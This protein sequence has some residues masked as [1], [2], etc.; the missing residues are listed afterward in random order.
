MNASRSASFHTRPHIALWLSCALLAATPAFAAK[1]LGW[2][3]DALALE[4]SGVSQLPAP[5]AGVT[6]LKFADFYKMPVGAEGLTPTEKIKALAGQRVRI[7]GFMVKQTRPSPGVAILAP[8]ALATHETE[9]DVCDDLPPAAL[10]VDV[11]KYADIAVPHTPGP[12]LLTG[13]LELGR[14]VEADGRVSFVRLILDP[15]AAA[16]SPA[17]DASPTPAAS[18]APRTPAS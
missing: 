9:Y 4:L 16:S 12:L 14:R 1:G 11:A 5:T 10:F 13:K 17:A 15:E 3:A 18:S 6:D 8:F 2:H 7:M